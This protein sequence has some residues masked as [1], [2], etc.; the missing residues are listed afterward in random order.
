M[1]RMFKID[2][3]DKDIISELIEDAKV[4]TRVLARKL[5]I[6]PNTLLQR[7]KR[8]EKEGVI[9][10]YTIVP[11]YDKLGYSFYAVISIKVKMQTD[12]E[13]KLKPIAALPQIAAFL[14]VTGDFDALAIARM[15]TKQD[16]TDVLRKLQKNDI[17]T[18][19]T[20]HLIVDGYKYY[21]DFNPFKEE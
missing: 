9:Q 7:I 6:H 15:K 20:T 3:L 2:N 18:Q 13:A 10:K 19:T 8:L 5:K 16:L 21:Y 12:W 1:V 14:L 4:S 17:V 11:D